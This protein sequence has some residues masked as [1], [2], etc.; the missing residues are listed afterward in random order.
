LPSF[1]GAVT[2]D[3]TFF[4]FDLDPE[5]GARHWVVLEEPPH[6]FQFYNATVQ[7]DG[8]PIPGFDAAR[9]AKF[10]GATDGANFADAAFADPYRV[11]IRG[12]ALISEAA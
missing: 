7:P 4:G 8:T 3:I 9:T 6:G 10:H 11:M 1:Q 12:S 2:P 5:L